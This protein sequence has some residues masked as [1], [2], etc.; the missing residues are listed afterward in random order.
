[1][2][3]PGSYHPVWLSI[4]VGLVLVA[5]FVAVCRRALR[6]FS[7][8]ALL[9]RVPAAEHAQLEESLGKDD[10][11]EAALERIEFTLCGLL[12]LCLVT[13]R[14]L[15]LAQYLAEQDEGARR[16]S[17]I[18]PTAAA[19]VAGLLAVEIGLVVTIV[20]GVVPALIG[21]IWPEAWLRRFLGV[22]EQLWRLLAPA[23]WVARRL[24]RYAVVFRGGNAPR[25]HADIVEEEILSAA[26]E[27][28][29]EGVL[30]SQD[31]DMIESIISFG[32]VEVSEVMT[33]RTEMVCLDLDDP[34]QQNLDTAI[35]CGHSRIPVYLERK[36]NVTGV[37]YVKDLLRH[38]Y[39]KEDIVLDSL[40]RKP[41]CVPRTKKIDELL[42]EFKAHRLH[43]AIV[44]DEYGGTDGLVTIEDI[45]EEIVGEIRDEYE[46][47]EPLPVQ[48][49]SKDLADVDATVHIDDLN[50]EL[51]LEIPESENYDTIGGFL[52]AS[53]GRVPAVGDTF[54]HDD[55]RF[56]V[57]SSDE[58]RVLRLEVKLP[59]ASG[60]PGDE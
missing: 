47:E 60:A 41:Y 39:R 18:G 27:G 44:L 59:S 46:K 22:I 36:D 23:R 16:L 52:F 24:W 40:V 25:S 28:G 43:I 20:L 14:L 5:F 58:R 2:Y 9:E 49:V 26:E 21:D 55:V 19:F 29:R 53:M 8:R 17:E 12:V 7:R 45:L 32:D 1:M 57:T 13:G 38:L 15:W 6:S 3:V 30:D 33:P 51:G 56:R 35:A 4:A 11:Y 42:Q 37:L 48:R 10:D 54:E 34:L 50:E 31:I